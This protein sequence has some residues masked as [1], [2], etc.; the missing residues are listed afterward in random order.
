LL[1]A[2]SLCGCNSLLSN[3]SAA[4]KIL[5][6]PCAMEQKEQ[7]RHPLERRPQSNISIVPTNVLGLPG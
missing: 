6:D 4:N 3:P 7:Y 2:V 1:E 5:D